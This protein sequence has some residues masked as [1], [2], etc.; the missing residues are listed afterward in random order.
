MNISVGTE[1]IF[2][3]TRPSGRPGSRLCD[4]I[5]TCWIAPRMDEIF[6]KPECWHWAP[7]FDAGCWEHNLG[8]SLPFL[9]RFFCFL[10]HSQGRDVC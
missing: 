5:I 10:A 2:I 7:K 6:K 9:L 4:S 1:S 8:F 3:E